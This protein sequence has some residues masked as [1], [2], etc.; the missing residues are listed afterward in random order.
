MSVRWEAV[1][2]RAR[3]LGTHLLD[4][5]GLRA[6]GRARDRAELV[7]MLEAGPYRDVVGRADDG[8]EALERAL[9]RYHAS[10]LQ[11]LVRWLG[12]DEAVLAPVF[13]VLDAQAVRAIVRGI[14]GGAPPAE[15]IED[16]IPT[17]RLGRRELA[18]LSTTGSVGA[19]VGLLRIWGHPL[20][21]ALAGEAEAPRPDPFR[22]EAALGR[23]LGDGLSEATRK[24]DAGLRAYAEEEID[25]W[26]AGA[27]LVLAGSDTEV[28]RRALFVEGGSAI[29]AD[30]FLAAASA[31][32]RD[33]GGDLLAEAARD[34]PLERP[35]RARPSAPAAVDD[36][37][38][39]ARIARLRAEARLRPLGSAP[40]L[41][42]VLRLRRERRALRHAIWRTSF[43][44]ARRP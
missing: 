18:L 4:D 14:L 39:D 43:S 10:R 13:L 29:D 7:G 27:A 6:L 38:L 42:F 12:P 3:G 34:T 26:N 24:G 31:P 17:P 16:A 20:G 44:R 40:A 8:A 15:R 11:I 2:A 35:L 41:L 5:E 23:G 21:P 36:R 1:A 33:R 9:T 28:D 30:A 32:D 25:A 22:L 37:I 19:L